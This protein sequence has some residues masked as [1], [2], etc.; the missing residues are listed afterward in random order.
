MSQSILFEQAFE[1]CVDTING[2]RSANDGSQLPRVGITRDGSGT[3]AAFDFQVTSG[4]TSNPTGKTDVSFTR[5]GSRLEGDG[6]EWGTWT[7][8]GQ[9]Q[10]GALDLDIPDG[11]GGR[12]HLFRLGGNSTND[13]TRLPVQVQDAQDVTLEVTANLGTIDLVTP[14]LMDVFL[15]GHSNATYYYVPLDG[16]GNFLPDGSGGDVVKQAANSAAWQF[17]T[18][19]DN[20]DVSFTQFSD[21]TFQNNSDQTWNIEQ[22]EVRKDSKNGPKVMGDFGISVD[23]TSGGSIT[24]TD[25]TLSISG[26]T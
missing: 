8:S 23:V 19:P 1:F 17:N 12:L 3:G 16:N 24:F 22:F 14:G 4:S 7:S 5:Q 6:S 21:V 10:L 26:L 2:L 18:T 13:D 15:Y 20:G 11:A 9:Q 25:I